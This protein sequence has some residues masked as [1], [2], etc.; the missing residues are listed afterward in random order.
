VPLTVPFLPSIH[1]YI[2]SS[3]A[4]PVHAQAALLIVIPS[5]AGPLIWAE[6]NPTLGSRP[7]KPFAPFL[8]LNQF[9][10]FFSFIHF[11][12]STYG[13]YLFSELQRI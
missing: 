1:V 8:K 13:V 7:D 10:C 9:F 6:V 4:V 12:I 2:Q 3:I 11:V 5:D